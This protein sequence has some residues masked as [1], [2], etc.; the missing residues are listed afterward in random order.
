MG[1]LDK[2]L[3]SP[4]T[5]QMAQRA[6]DLIDPNSA[7]MRQQM[8]GFQKQASDNAYT[9]NRL[10]KQRFA[11]SGLLGQSG[12]MNQIQNQNVGAAGNQAMQQFGNMQQNNI[13]ASTQLL[14][15]VAQADIAKRQ[16]MANAMSQNVASKNEGMAAMGGGLL[17]MAGSLMG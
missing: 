2:Q 3:T 17:Q 11:G 7:L 1:A 10:A 14:Q 4:Y 5:A 12:I 13:G 8:S 6:D 16:G 9:Q 15:N